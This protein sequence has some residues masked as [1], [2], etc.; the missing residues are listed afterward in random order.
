MTMTNNQQTDL[1]GNPVTTIPAPSGRGR[2]DSN[3]ID[4]MHT[5]AGNAVRCGYLLVG[6]AE[7]VY[8]RTDHHHEVARVPRYEDDAVHQL[9]RRHWLTRGSQHR[10]RCGAAIPARHRRP[11]PQNHPR[12]DHPLGTAAT[13]LVL[14]HTCPPTPPPRQAPAAAGGGV[15]DLDQHR[16]RR[17]P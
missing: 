10:I 15:V 8:T 2:V 3:D 1:F 6:H 14:A 16:Q 13:P 17:R 11:R 12:A 9:L 4:L 7:R 5:I